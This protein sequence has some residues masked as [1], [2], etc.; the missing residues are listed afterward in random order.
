MSNF[1]STT[2]VILLVMAISLG[3]GFVVHER[4]V[5]NELSFQKYILYIA[6]V[7]QNEKEKCKFILQ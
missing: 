6:C 5:K 3:G 1:L 4:I 2:I 7:D